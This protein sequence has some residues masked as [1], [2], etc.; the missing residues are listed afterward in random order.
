LSNQKIMARKKT[1]IAK[2]AEEAGLSTATVDRVLNNRPGVNA[3]TEEKVKRALAELGGAAPQRGRPRQ[4][5]NYRFAYVLP[6]TRFAFFDSVDRHIAQSASAFRDQHIT[7][8]THRLDTGDVNLLAQEL[9]RFDHYDGIALLAPDLPQVK[10]AVNQLVSAGVHAVTIFSD[11]SGCMRETF[12]SADNRAAGRTAGLL[13]GRMLPYRKKLQVAVFSQSTRFSADIDRRVGFAQIHEERFPWLEVLRMTELPESE[14]EALAASRAF[15]AD[16]PLLSGIYNVGSCT[17]GIS[18][19]VNELGAKR[20]IPIVG[21]DLTETTRALLLSGEI[22]YVLNED[23][24][25]CILTA[26]RALR[27]LCDNLRGALGVV[28][29][30]IEILTSENLT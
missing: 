29:P 10:L 26:A 9:A 24:R 2:I 27:A 3:E 20:R 12:V 13:L 4:R 18:R 5:P 21:H 30:R 6:A 28:Q 23:I 22:A 14:E 15:L 7:E 17:F 16:K 19:A 1:T 8:V 11:V 25:Y